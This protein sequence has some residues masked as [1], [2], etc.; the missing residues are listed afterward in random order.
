MRDC[1][2]SQLNW[3][4]LFLRWPILPP[5]FFVMIT[6]YQGLNHWPV[7]D[8]SQLPG[9]AIYGVPVDAQIPFVPI[10]LLPYLSFFAFY[11]LHKP[12]LASSALSSRRFWRMEVVLVVM[13]VVSCACFLL[14]PTQIELRQQALESL[15]SGVYPAWLVDACLGLFLLDNEIN[16]WPSI[17]VSQ[18]LFIM[19]CVTR[20]QLYSPHK[21]AMLWLLLLTV[22][23]SVLTLKQ[24]Y[25]WDVATGVL[26]ALASVQ[27]CFS[28][29]SGIKWVQ[30]RVGEA[31]R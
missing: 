14:F 12:L 21:L 24:H 27:V 3:R 15:A 17:H 18:P 4:R 29:S 26:L 16:A 19:L 30:P 10:S 11:L 5:S 20:M 1:D 22:M 25:V 2:N 13:S 9:L 8:E 7:H 6:L 28:W 31:I 23:V